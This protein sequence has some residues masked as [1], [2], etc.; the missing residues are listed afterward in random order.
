MKVETYYCDI[1]KK[2]V[3]HSKKQLL[4]LAF[5]DPSY[6]SFGRVKRYEVCGECIKKIEK[7]LDDIEQ[8]E[9]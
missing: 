4:E 5:E 2:E 7:L 6:W 3:G 1:C 8:G 9:K